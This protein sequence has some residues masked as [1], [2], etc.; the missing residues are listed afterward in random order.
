MTTK[1][2]LLERLHRVAI[3]AI[4]L[5]KVTEAKP[6]PANARKLRAANDAVEKLLTRLGA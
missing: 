4:R 1:A 6:T 3:R 5:M 2:K